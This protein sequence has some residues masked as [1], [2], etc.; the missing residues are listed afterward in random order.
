MRLLHVTMGISP[1]AGGPTRS[2][3]GLCRALD[4]MGEEI[5]LLVL[6]GNHPFVNPGNVNIIHGK[7]PD[8]RAYDIVHLHGLWDLGLH[9]VAV[10]C[11]R[12]D[13]PYVISPRGMLDPWALGVKKWKKRLAMFFY[14]RGD[15]RHSVAFHATAEEEARHIR[16]LGFKQ[17]II[18]APNG[19]DLPSV[20]PD[21]MGGNRTAIFLSRLH[22]GKGL[23]TLAEAWALVRPVGWRM[24]VIGPDSYGHKKDVVAR[25]DQLGITREWEFADAMD[26]DRKWCAYRSADLLIHPSVSENFGITIAEGL[27]AELPVICTKGTP[28]AEVDTQKCGWWIDVGVEPLAEALRTATMLSDDER[29]EMG[30]NGRRLVEEKYTWDAVVKEI[31]KGYD[32]VIRC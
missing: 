24:L 1:A 4:K 32:E 27:A 9:K 6:H 16:L 25:L 17:Q 11:R 8:V 28:W 14:Q 30:A 29:R 19:V 13:I 26:D 15:L 3:T 7:V 22:P 12:Y 2:V 20:M 5:S 23:L 10:E 18:I 21:R 31:V